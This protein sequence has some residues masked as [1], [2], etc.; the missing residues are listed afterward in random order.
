MSRPRL[1]VSPGGYFSGPAWEEWPRSWTHERYESESGFCRDLRRRGVSGARYVIGDAHERLAPSD[2]R[3]LSGAA[4]QCCIVRLERNVC[5]L[6]K[7]KRRRKAADIAPKTA[8]PHRIV[9]A[10]ADPSKSGWPFAR[11]T[12]G[13]II[14]EWHALAFVPLP[15]PMALK[16]FQLALRYAYRRRFRRS[17]LR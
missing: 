9:G 4:R 16:L 15:Y 1:T 8:R 5:S 12:Y 7:S 11:T 13:G 3:M 2:G 17:F 6:L 10:G 14:L